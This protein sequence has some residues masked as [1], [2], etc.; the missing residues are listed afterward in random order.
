MKTF[1]LLF[2][3]AS[4]FG[5]AAFQNNCKRKSLKGGRTEANSARQ[6]GNS[7]SERMKGGFVKESPSPA[8]QPE[9]SKGNELTAKEIARMSLPAL[10]LIIADNGS[11]SAQG[12]GFFIQPGVVVTNYHVV[13]DASSGFIQVEFWDRNEI[14]HSADAEVV[15]F[16][17]KSDLA[18]LEIPTAKN[19]TIQILSLA[20]V[21][22]STE[23]GEM[24]YAVGNP[25]GLERV[26]STGIVSAQIR[27]FERSQR[28][29]ITAPI[30]HGSSGGPIINS[31]G[32]VIGV[33][34]STVED[35]QNLN[36]A[37]PT[38]FVYSL[39]KTSGNTVTEA[40]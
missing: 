28:F 24:V 11:Q 25:K 37:I 39:I 27:D 29:Q 12:S 1:A 31:R 3:I 32:K 5:T 35:G 13:S 9:L 16:D 21:N 36:F 34:V 10:V 23:V 40:Q 38:K 14:K 20:N 19:A 8:P 6:T 22:E 15:K 30:S 2:L 33:A 7:E 18:I 26:V 17:E 4:V